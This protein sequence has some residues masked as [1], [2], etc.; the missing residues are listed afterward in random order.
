MKVDY[1]PQVGYRRT[2][3]EDLYDFLLKPVSFTAEPDS[4]QITAETYRG[5]RAEVKVCFLTGTVF[6]LQM[7]PQIRTMRPGN[8]VFPT[9]VGAR[10][11]FGTGAFL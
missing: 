3:F 10:S 11:V 2:V 1:N 7:I 6:R 9:A 5:E 8:P 4:L